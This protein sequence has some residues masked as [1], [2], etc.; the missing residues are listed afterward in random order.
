MYEPQ[1]PVAI[2]GAGADAAG[3]DR[4][5]LFLARLELRLATE[6]NDRLRALSL[7]SGAA[8]PATES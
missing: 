7:I 3:P 4:T 5:L 2:V 6:L 1:Q 8:L